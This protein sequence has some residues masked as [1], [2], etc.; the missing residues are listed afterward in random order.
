VISWTRTTLSEI[1]GNAIQRTRLHQQTEQRLQHLTAL[2][3]IDRVIS[4]SLDLRLSL[5]TLIEQTISQ[6]HVDAV[7]LLLLTPSSLTLDY[8]AGRG[9]HT[10]GITQTHLHLGEGHAGRAALEGRLVHIPDI[11]LP[12]NTPARA[13][14]LQGEGFAAYIGVPL[15]A[16]GM[17]KGVLEI[18]HRA[19]LRLDEEWLDFLATLAQ[20]AAIAVENM[21]LFHGLQQSNMELSLAYDATI[22]GWSHALDLRDKETEGHTQRVTEMTLRLARAMGLG[23]EEMVHVRRGALLHDIGKMGVPDSILL[24][25]GGLTDDEWIVMRKH[26]TYAYELLY[27]I[28]YLRSALDIPYCHHEKWDGTGYPRG[29]KGEQVPLVARI[30]AVVDMYDALCA[31]RP[32]RGAWPEERVREYIREQSGRHFDPKVVEAFLQIEGELRQGTR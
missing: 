23:E 22:E 32:Y 6:L 31:D 4:S 26:P 15:I 29:L 3:D 1:A 18:F 12:E 14:L 17:V 9:F 11:T 8:V 10:S 24:K 7:D 2:R 20:Q 27:P 13:A 28:H 19:P 21:Q 25:P 30:F 16:K 5:A